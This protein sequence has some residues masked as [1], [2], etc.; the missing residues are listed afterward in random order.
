MNEK[1]ERY[2]STLARSVN[3]VETYRWAL[4]CYFEAVGDDVLDNDAYKLFLESIKWYAPSTKLVLRSA[5]MGLYDFC[6]VPDR[7]KRDR[8]NE[9]YIGTVKSSPVNFNRGAIEKVI[10]YC[11]NLRGGLMEM[12]DRAFILTLADSGFRISELV[13]VKRG[14]VDWL[15]RRVSV[16]G[17]GNKPALVRLS[18][19]STDALKEYLGLRE[20]GRYGKPLNSLPLFVQ[21]GNVSKIKPMTI[22]GM[23][24]AV[25]ARIE[26]AG[27]DKESVRLHDF[28]HYFVTI[29]LLA[30]NN[31]KIAQ[32][33]ARH[34]ST[35]TTQRYAHLAESDLD[36]AY[37]DIFNRKHDT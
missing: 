2:L 29:A 13:S 33:L 16:V 21:H 7:E 37:D 4:S 17:K 20:D 15:D 25:K 27:V 3:T 10:S 8:L 12:R 34:E 11:E 14:D 5:V 28:R 9:H 32:D 36:E 18:E 19:R 31:L 26:E 30:S 24:K 23:R 22:D 6:E 1:T 35:A